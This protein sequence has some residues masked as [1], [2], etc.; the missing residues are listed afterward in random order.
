MLI[1]PGVR[2]NW[3]TAFD[4]K[5]VA[6]PEEAFNKGADYLIIGRPITDAKNPIDA[7]AKITNKL[8]L[9]P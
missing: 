9:M 6:T 8:K 7:A 3:S 5:R 4:Q 1:V 2:P